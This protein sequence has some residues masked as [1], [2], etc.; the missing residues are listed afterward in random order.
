M[1]FARDLFHSSTCLTRADKSRILTF[2][3]GVR[4]EYYHPCSEE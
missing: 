1:K 2:I 4:G 3:S